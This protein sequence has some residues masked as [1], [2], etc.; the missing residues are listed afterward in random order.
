[1]TVPSN[2]SSTRLSSLAPTQPAQRSSAASNTSAAAPNR[3]SAGQVQPSLPT[4]LLGHHV[5]TTA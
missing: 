3:E 4:G 5:N 1:M 2:L